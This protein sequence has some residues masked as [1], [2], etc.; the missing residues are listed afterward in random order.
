MAAE[1]MT[2]EEKIEKLIQGYKALQD[3]YRDE[4]AGKA[5]A[6]QLVAETHKIVESLEDSLKRAEAD[7]AD[8]SQEVSQ[9]KGELK[10]LAGKAEKFELSSK[11][12]AAK[13]DDILSQLTDL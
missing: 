12:A 13:I 7:L 9:L 11:T 6:E 4:Q 10:A 8:K 1:N 5:T 2:L 3:K